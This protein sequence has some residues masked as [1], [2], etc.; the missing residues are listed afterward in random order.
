MKLN[1]TIIREHLPEG[2]RTQQFGPEDEELVCD[3]PILYEA[4]DEIRPGAFYVARST[5]IPSETLP[6]DVSLICVGSH[7]PVEWMDGKSRV[8]LVTSD[9]SVSAVFNAVQAIYDRFDGFERELLAALARSPFP[10]LETVVGIGAD[11]LGNNVYV[12]DSRLNIVYNAKVTEDEDGNH[13]VTT[14]DVAYPLDLESRELIRIDSRLNRV[15]EEAYPINYEGGDNGERSTQY[16]CQNILFEGHYLGAIWID[17][18]TRPFGECDF[19]LAKIFFDYFEKAYLKSMVRLSSSESPQDSA[20]EKLIADKPLSSEEYEALTCKSSESWH[21]FRLKARNDERS[22]PPD[23]MCST[24]ET[25]FPTHVNAVLSGQDVI[26]LLRLSEEDEDQAETR[27]FSSNFSD[28][29]ARMNYAGGC[30]SAFRELDRFGIFYLEATYA[31][32]Q[33]LQSNAGGICMFTS[34]LLPYMLY[35]CSGKLPAEALYSPG[36]LRLVDYDATRG[37]ELLKTL[38]VYLRNET[39]IPRT[40]EQLF[41]HRTSLLKRLDRI[42]K[43]TGDDLGD[44]DVRL[45]YRMC[46]AL[47]SH[48]IVARPK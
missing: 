13:T 6:S 32:Q 25:I 27:E 30:S 10:D 18:E 44:P 2:F 42:Q 9:S 31:A 21:C 15:K 34:Q 36:L 41:I 17:D 39:S 29:V 4:G 19:E 20:L 40:S 47:W 22:L 28:L 1:L 35:E 14:S 3:R 43:V 45:Y 48:G 16:F 5:R 12:N 11:M 26:G 37:T 7:I 8:L 24:L 38:D 33:A 23:Y 46:F